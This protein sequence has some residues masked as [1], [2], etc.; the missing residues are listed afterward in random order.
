[1]GLVDS[2][3]G[4]VPLGFVDQFLSL[5]VILVPQ[6]KSLTTKPEQYKS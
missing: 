1:M 2:F 3:W 4:V 6:E 5:K